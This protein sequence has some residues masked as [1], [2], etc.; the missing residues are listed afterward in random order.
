ME[1]WLFGMY[2]LASVLAIVQA[3]LVIVQTWEHHRF[4]RS[5]LAIMRRYPRKGRALVIV[6]CRGVD[7]RQAGNLRTL[8]R[9]DY[10]EY[11]I[12]GTLHHLSLIH[13]SEPTRPY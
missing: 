5:R 8:F 3:S 9:Q 1:V 4:A 10:G 7:I 6:P 11:Q 13:I 2:I 12:R